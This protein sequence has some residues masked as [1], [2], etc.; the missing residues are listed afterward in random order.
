[1]FGGIGAGLV[2]GRSAGKRRSTDQAPAGGLVSTAI[3]WLVILGMAVVTFLPRLSIALLR[4]E[5]LPPALAR[6]LLRATGGVERDRFPASS[7][8]TVPDLAGS[9][10]AGLV[11]VVV[12]WWS[13]NTLGRSPW[14][15]LLWALQAV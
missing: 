2:A 14:M 1:M 12:A 11:A 10:P 3:V 7:C 5:A 4:R 9:A 13:R 8:R 6:A 15:L